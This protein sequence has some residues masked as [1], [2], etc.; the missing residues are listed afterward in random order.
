MAFLELLNA[1]KI[2]WCCYKNDFL[3]EETVCMV[4]VIAIARYCMFEWTC[5]SLE[6]IC[7]I[8]DSSSVRIREHLLMIIRRQFHVHRINVAG[9]AEIA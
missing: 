6:Y 3:R 4:F 7:Y 8:R 1:I 2:H 5:V 9:I